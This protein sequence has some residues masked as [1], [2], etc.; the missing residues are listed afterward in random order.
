MNLSGLQHRIV[1]NFVNLTK[2]PLTLGDTAWRDVVDTIR[3]DLANDGCAVL[4]SFILPKALARLEAESA[5]MAINAY[6]KTEIVNAYNININT[7]LPLWHPGNLTMERGNA[8]VARDQIPTASIIQQ[9]YTDSL[10]KSFI[11][12]CFQLPIIHEL[13]DP[14][15]GLVLNVIA[16]GKEHPWHFD[17]NEFTVSMLTQAPEAGGVFEYCPYIR[18]P[19]EEHF[20]DV[21]NVLKGSRTP[22]I[23]R[24]KL[25]PGDLQLFMGRYSLHRVSKVKGE[26]TRHS[27]IFAYSERNGVVGNPARTLQLFGRLAP[28]HTANSVVRNDHLLD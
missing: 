6:F 7:V 5:A 16:P 13:A 10:F 27:A 14:F 8:F 26:A 3:H 11:A 15:A 19:Q 18:T 2:Y 23:R 21:N 4:P 12:D 24:I 22:S 28:A 20:D 17:T 25:C 1:K 9:I